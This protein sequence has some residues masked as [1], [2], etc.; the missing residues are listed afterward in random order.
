MFTFNLL[1]E[2]VFENIETINKELPE[3]SHLKKDLELIIFGDNSS[4]DSL[5]FVNLVISLE[6]FFL[7]E[8]NTEIFLLDAF[9]D[10]DDNFES[11][12]DLI[13][14]LKKLLSNE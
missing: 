11:L 3:E 10:I 5:N 8:H 4:I 7:R 13:I 14:L 2:I 9:S 1:Q 12:R 6:D